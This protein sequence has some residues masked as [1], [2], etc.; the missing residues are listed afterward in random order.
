MPPLNRERR[1]EIDAVLRCPRCGDAPYTV[2]RR[3]HVQADGQLLP[4]FEHVLWP[5]H[6]NVPPPVHP[7][8]IGCPACGTELKRSGR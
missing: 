3:Q 1:L 4:S 7:E 5:A 6:P 2:F 8:Q